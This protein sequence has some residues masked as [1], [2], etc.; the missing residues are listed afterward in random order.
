MNIKFY[1]SDYL[2]SLLLVILLLLAGTNANAHNV[3]AKNANGVTIY[4]K[5]INNYT[6]LAVSYKG[7]TLGANPNVYSGN[8]V[9]PETVTISGKTY[10]VTTIGEGAFY[11]CY[12]LNSVT[13][14]SSVTT[15]ENRA[16]AEC[17]ITSMT[18]P[19]TVTSIGEKTFDNCKS[20]ESVTIPD[21]ITSIKKNMFSR[22]ESLTSVNIPNS[23]TSIGD[24]AFSGCSSLASI[25]IPGSV[26]TIGSNAFN[27]CTSLASI[28]IPDGVTSLGGYAFSGCTS[29]ASVSIPNSV[30]EFGTDPFQ[31]CTQI[32]TVELNNNTIASAKRSYTSTLAKVFGDQVQN[33]VIGSDVKSIGDYAFY[34]LTKL[35]SVVIQD[36]VKS[37]GTEAFAYCNGLS[38]LDIPN[39]VTDI[40]KQAF[41][42]CS[43]LTS[44]NIPN[45]LTSIS[46]MLF[47]GCSGLTSVAIPSSVTFIGASAFSGCS[48]LTAV[49]I[50]DLS[51]WCKIDFDDTSGTGNPLPKAHHLYLNGEE[52]KE[53]V[54]PDDVTSLYYGAFRGC[55]G[56]TSVTIPDNVKA[57]DFFA[58][59]DCENLNTVYLNSNSVASAARESTKSLYK[60]FGKQVK[61]YIIGEGVKSIGDN[62]FNDCSGI[63]SVTMP[64]SLTS[65][66]ASAFSGC[67]GLTSLTIPSSVTS[68][69]G[70]AFDGCSGLTAVN[71]SDIA[72]WYKVKFGNSSANP[73]SCAH[74]L[75]LNEEEIKELVVPEEV[76]SLN[77]YAFYGCSGLTS[78]TI[79]VA[80]T[81]IGSEAFMGCT[82]LNTVYLNS[83]NIVSAARESSTSLNKYFG[84][85]VKDY[86]LGNDVKS[87][88]DFAFSGCS[89]MTSLTMPNSLTSIGISAF[90]SCSGLTS[91][92]IPSSV[93]SIGSSA[94]DGCSGLTAVNISDMAAWYKLSF[95]NSSANPLSCAHHLFLNGEEIKELVIPAEIAS[96]NDYAFYGSGLTSV[97]IPNTLTAIGNEVFIE[98]AQLK[99]VYLNNNSMASAE[100]E[101]ATSL[102][103]TFGDQVQDYVLGDGVEAIG[104]YV[105]ND[106]TGLTSVTIPNSVTSIGGSAF[107]GCGNLS[108]LVLP[109]NITELGSACFGDN[110]KLFVNKKT[111]SLLCLWNAG[112]KPYL[113]G[114]DNILEPSSLAVLSTTQTTATVKINN[115]YDDYTYLKQTDDK[116]YE[117]VTD[118]EVVFTGL[119]PELSSDVYVYVSLDENMKLSFPM[120]VSCT[121]L[122][123]EPVINYESTASTLT[124]TCSYT[125]GDA[126][127]VSQRLVSDP[128]SMSDSRIVGGTECNSISYFESGLKPSTRYSFAYE[129]GVRMPNGD[130][131]YYNSGITQL[132]TK[133]LNFTTLQPK[134]ISEGNVI[135]GAECNL[136]EK[137]QNVGFEWRREDWTADF[138]SNT[139]KAKLFEGHMEYYIRKLYTEKLW[140][141]RPYYMSNDGTYFYGSWMGLDPTNTS[142]CEPTV[143]THTE[144]VVDGNTALVKGYIMQGSDNI[145]SQGFKYWKDNSNSSRSKKSAEAS[146]IPDDAKTIESK[147]SIMETTLTGLEY[148]ATYCFV[149]F[150]TTSEDE[151]FYGDVKTF[152]IP[153][154]TSLILGDA[155][156]D[157]VV[158]I[159]DAVIV[160][161]YLLGI[162]PDKFDA[163]AADADKSGTV[164]AGDIAAICRIIMSLSKE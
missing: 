29:L 99:T 11:S 110:T 102:C 57:I 148:D 87:I 143:L 79:P 56:L 136:D 23:V 10:N 98:C 151:T 42:D 130:I 19:N 119:H 2:K 118:D 144:V 80:M 66:G 133:A 92:T 91:I 125:E 107:T 35:K 44:V 12:G 113:T 30:T 117:V 71:I 108:S 146:D 18:I 37:I 160:A 94:F 149:A 86:I 131:A 120:S 53:L 90:S 128:E 101:A 17:S 43:S 82:Q 32:N 67:S 123:I 157:G 9:I 75:Y 141:Y 103:K 38:T 60:Y 51:A 164:D 63:I 46:Y 55:S 15:F 135:I 77:G 48:G 59:Y 154:N 106:C 156:S 65:I 152:D 142:Y 25:T 39:S 104:A 114:T 163:T 26:T 8:L 138:A 147:G 158:N 162:V 95:G 36:G 49:H 31:N 116:T 81:S 52:V 73:L 76:T 21:G 100:R 78:V 89:G 7:S 50:T 68:I 161:N 16:F 28:T 105:F 69:G 58:F 140:K 111:S 61:N 70:S 6:E 159:A 34:E 93:T 41:Y 137:E 27:K 127:V 134:V 96:L 13:I 124:V 64:N 88:G 83:D 139:A 153:V 22:C 20:L 84:N 45:G 5:Y 126:E 129:V 122:T 150:A 115:K 1:Y 97:T 62:A 54:I 74:H 145:V 85:Q 72:S 47:Y 40:G 121:T 109:D 132:S 14:P 112:Y 24:Y 155:N 4:Y 3:E 33:Y